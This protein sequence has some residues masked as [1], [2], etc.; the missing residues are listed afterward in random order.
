MPIITL[1]DTRDAR[2][3]LRSLR[4]DPYPVTGWAGPASFRDRP[5]AAIHVDTVVEP[6]AIA[7]YAET[8]QAVCR[9]PLARPR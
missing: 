7:E 4:D 2:R 8:V 3:A 5:A 1:V 6:A 9:Y